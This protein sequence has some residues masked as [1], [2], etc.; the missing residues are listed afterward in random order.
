VQRGCIWLGGG[1]NQC[2]NLLDFIGS[3]IDAQGRVHVAYADGC[4]DTCPSGGANTY[5]ALATI[6]RQTGGT[7]LLSAYDAAP[8]TTAKKGKRGASQQR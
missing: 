3:E 6:A 1:S 8:A 5:S 4:T 7:G 2:R